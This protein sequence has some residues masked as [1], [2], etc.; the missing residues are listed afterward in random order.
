MRNIY[1]DFNATTPV[2]PMVQE[3]MLPF[4]KEHYGNPS[5]THA[6]GRACH[7]AIEDARLL[8]RGR[9]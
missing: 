9:N 6:L 5:S 7:E 8:V 4:L 1:L 2:A 3:A